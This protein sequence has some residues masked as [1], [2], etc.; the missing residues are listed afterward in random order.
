MP[1][2]MTVVHRPTRVQGKAA[3]ASVDLK[4]NPDLIHYL[5]C[6]NVLLD[7]AV[8]A[9][10]PSQE[11]TEWRQVEGKGLIQEKMEME[12]SGDG[13]ADSAAIQPSDVETSGVQDWEDD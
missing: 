7:R 4:D 9:T 5:S 8:S 13:D 6:N 10:R 3:H 2:W 11:H 1:I 12:Q